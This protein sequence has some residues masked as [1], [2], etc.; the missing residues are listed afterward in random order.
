MNT[1]WIKPALADL[2]PYQRPYVELVP[3]G[4]LA[5]ILEGNAKSTGQLLASLSPE[6]LKFRYAE[7]KWSIPQMLMH[8]IDAERIFS[9]RILCIA[10]GD[11]TPLPGFEENDYAKASNQDE[12]N[13]KD[14]LEEYQSMRKA[15]ICLFKS[16]NNEMLS[17][18][19][20]SNTKEVSVNALCYVVT[21]HEMHHLKVIKTKYL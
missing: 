5:D 8:I 10:R 6:K 19:G 13:F 15:T 1:K 16:L 21:G 18:T 9:Y 2:A 12:R 20:I 7:G 11:K 4:N 17:R 3:E 14:I